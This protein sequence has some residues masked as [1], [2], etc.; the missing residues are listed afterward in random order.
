MKPVSAELLTLLATRQFFAADLYTFS[1]GNL[2]SNV[3]R[4][5]GGDADI[6]ANGFL[7]SA[8]GQVGPYF[9]RKDNKAKCH[10]KVGVEVDTLVFDVLPGSAQIFGTGFL[11]AVRQG[12][13]DGAELLLE[14]AYMPTYG[15]TRRG[16]V[17][18]FLGRVAEVDAGR[19]LATFTVNS[20]LELFNL[21]MPRNLYQP[22]CVNSLGD[23]SC[24]VSPIP[25]TTG[26]V[27]AGSTS[28]QIIATLAGGPFATGTFDLGKVQFTSGVLNGLA[29][30]AKQ[31][32]LSSPAV[33]T[34]LGY[35]PTAPSPGDTLTLF[36]GCDKSTGPNGCPKFNN[37]GRYRGFPF[38]PQPATAF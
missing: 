20:H 25:S 6:T 17:R 22:G 38:V 26:T 32:A 3:L 30:T 11:A 14:R 37:L 16:T 12:V 9:D 28:A 36:F 13:F 1:G 4:Y 24:G 19:S 29:L 8:G 33:I 27:Q 35:F 31:V 18:Y 2:G 7:F 21:Q 10:W 23:P 34:L 5:C 15:D